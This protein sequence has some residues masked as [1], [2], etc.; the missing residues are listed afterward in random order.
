MH[1]QHSSWLPVCPVT[2][3]R[4]RQQPPASR[5]PYTSRRP[6]LRR[7]CSS[8]RCMLNNIM[9]D[10]AMTNVS[11]INAVHASLDVGGQL[12]HEQQ[13]RTPA[14]TVSAADVDV[15]AQPA[16]SHVVMVDSSWPLAVA[17]ATAGAAVDAVE[18]VQRVP[19]PPQQSTS[20]APPLKKRA[21]SFFSR[22]LTHLDPLRLHAG[23]GALYLVLSTGA[24][25]HVLSHV[26]L[27]TASSHTPCTTCSSLR[28]L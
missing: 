3:R 20:T 7:G 13:M 11:G 2:S 28:C 8:S 9:R 14:S 17:A 22:L 10:A 15:D 27:C 24:A 26:R 23:S 12:V 25:L 19:P 5:T 18:P 16:Q 1:V 4:S 21:K 6:P